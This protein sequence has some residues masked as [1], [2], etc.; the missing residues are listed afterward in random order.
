MWLY[1]DDQVDILA[2][3]TFYRNKGRVDGT[4]ELVSYQLNDVK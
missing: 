1:I 3:P 4:L 2:D